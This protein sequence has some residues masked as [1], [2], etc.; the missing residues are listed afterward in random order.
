MIQNRN[1]VE[2]STDLGRFG[3]RPGIAV[4]S[5]PCWRISTMTWFSRVRRRCVV[6]GN[7]VV[8]GKAALRAYWTTAMSR[9]GSLHFSVDRVLWDAKSRELAIIYIAGETWIG[10]R[11]CRRTCVSTHSGRVVSA[12]VF[13][14]C[15]GMNS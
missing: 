7:A 9:I 1:A 12:E 13:H 11:H 14:G 5:R 2:L 10:K 6:T 8:R 3:P 15:G 4:T